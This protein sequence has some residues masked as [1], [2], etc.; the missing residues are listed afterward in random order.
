[1]KMY[2]F[3]FGERRGIEQRSC[4]MR[5]DKQTRLNEKVLAEVKMHM[6]FHLANAAESSSKAARCDLTSSEI[7]SAR[8][9]Q[10][11]E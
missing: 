10:V 7:Q 2:A 8:K 5:F 1:M 9:K 3:S 4:E 6:H 11:L